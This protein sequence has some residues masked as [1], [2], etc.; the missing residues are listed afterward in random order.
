LQFD[1]DADMPEIRQSRGVVLPRSGQVVAF[2]AALGAVWILW[3]EAHEQLA[4]HGPSF[5]MQ[6]ANERLLRI[7]AL[8]ERGTPAIPELIALLTDSEP[9][10]RRDALLGLE[11]FGPDAGLAVGA[12]RERLSDENPQVREFALLTLARICENQDDVIAAAAQQVVD[13]NDDV[14]ETAAR[15]LESMGRRVIPFMIELA[16]RDHPLARRQA[17]RILRA[18]DRRRDPQEVTEVLRTL[19]HDPIAEVRADAVAAVSARG[20]ATTEDVR[21]WLGE[22]NPALVDAALR[23]VFA[24]GPDAVTLLPELVSLLDSDFA[25]PQLVCAALGSLKTAARKAVPVLCQRCESLAEADRLTAARTLVE[26]GADTDQVVPILNR[27]LSSPTLTIRVES[28]GVLARVDPDEARRHV[29]RMIGELE[30]DPTTIN[31]S[32]MFLLAAMGPEADEAVPLLIRLL[33]HPDQAVSTNAVDALGKIGQSAAHTAPELVGLLDTRHRRSPFN[34]ALIRALGGIGPPA[35]RAVP[36]LLAILNQSGTTRGHSAT[37]GAIAPG[38][39]ADAVWALGR[40][41]DDAPEV[42]AALIRLLTAG[43][44]LRRPQ[45]MAEFQVLALQ[46]LVLLDPNSKAT[47]RICLFFIKGQFWILRSQAALAIGCVKGDR[48]EA[49]ETLSAALQDDEWIVQTCAALALGQIGPDAK[50]AVPRLREMCRDRRNEVPNRLRTQ[51]PTPELMFVPE[52]ADLGRLSVAG[53]ARW[54]LATIENRGTQESLV[55]SQSSALS[56]SLLA[57]IK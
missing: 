32:P 16:G 29:R 19:L 25:P 47:A 38:V 36:D 33:S 24:L 2:V 5:Q 57:G 22:G 43:D 10:M 50:P 52:G 49:V 46:S 7:D 28:A 9:K 44:S 6:R 40:I 15:R 3:S 1:Q 45:E 13:S 23:A 30:A 42:L 11:R 20:A 39:E 27:L 35:R 34:R 8:V 12:V 31:Q 17:V 21:G 51:A 53:A 56:A 37:A 26:I 18:A 55:E 41:G 54:A 14:R 4:P 48:R